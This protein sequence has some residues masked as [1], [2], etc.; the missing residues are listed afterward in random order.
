MTQWKA[1]D[2]RHSQGDP[3]EVLTSFLAITAGTVGALRADRSELDTSD[4]ALI[5]DTDEDIR[6][7]GCRGHGQWKT[8]ATYF[9]T[10]S[11]RQ[12]TSSCFK[13]T[14]LSPD[15]TI[16]CERRQPDQHRG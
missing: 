9:S 6:E 8:Q 11:R 12:K 15:S 16:H 10:T 13:T 3:H 14:P 4:D 5:E 1:N 2:R 7:H